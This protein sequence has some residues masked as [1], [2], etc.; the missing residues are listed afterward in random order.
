M[1][2]VV[3]PDMRTILDKVVL[4]IEGGLREAGYAPVVGDSIDGVPPGGQ[5][6]VLGAN[7]FGAN[8]LA[9]LARNSIVL[10]VENVSSPFISADYL[11]LMRNFH[12]WDYSATN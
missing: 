5:A 11:A 7:H 9:G 10:N 12:V 4:M 3:H 8:A 1:H 6:I 2:V